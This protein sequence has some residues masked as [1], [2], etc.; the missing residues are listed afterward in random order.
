MAKNK[1]KEKKNTLINCNNLF[2]KLKQLP[3]YKNAL[4]AENVV[5]QAPSMTNLN[6]INK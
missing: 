4:H 6:N 2:I 5:W 3:I 1:K